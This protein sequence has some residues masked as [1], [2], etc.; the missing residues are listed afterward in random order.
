[1]PYRP[2]SVRSC[3]CVV[4][5][6]ERCQHMIAA[7]RARKAEHDRIR[8]SAR[9]RGYDSR[10]QRESKMFLLAHPY[11][12][13]CQERASTVVHHIIAH[14]GDRLKFWNRNNWQAVCKPCHDGPLQ[15]REK[16]RP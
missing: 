5:Y 4:A 3:G 14:K 11:C 6:G 13:H 2:P 1:M 12:Q 16:R 15:S 10:W 9:Q 7:D 8:P